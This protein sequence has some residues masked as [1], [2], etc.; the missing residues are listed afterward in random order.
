MDDPSSAEASDHVK[1][2]KRL[3]TEIKRLNEELADAVKRA[4]HIG[5]TPTEASVY[6]ARRTTLVKLAERLRQLELEWS[7]E[8]SKAAFVERL[9]VLVRELNNDLGLI[10]GYCELLEERIKADSECARRARQ[11]KE[12]ALS[13]AQKLNVWKAGAGQA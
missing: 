8:Q 11:I 12:I 10:V 4:T 7:G 9:R 1:T 13:M 6:D 5:M 3:Q 2:I